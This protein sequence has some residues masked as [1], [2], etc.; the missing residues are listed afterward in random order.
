M[1]HLKVPLFYS[2]SQYENTFRTCIF[3]YFDCVWLAITI[4]WINIYLLKWH[5]LFTKNGCNIIHTV[6]DIWFFYSFPKGAMKTRIEFSDKLKKY[7]KWICINS[8][9]LGR[10]IDYIWYLWH[11]WTS[12]IG[13][14]NLN[15]WKA[16]YFE[17]V[18]T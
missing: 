13:V 3:R 5:G 18:F 6:N 8:S 14:S 12:I 17:D 9:F 15:V 7:I 2:N 10:N 16:L 11:C 1:E 4:L